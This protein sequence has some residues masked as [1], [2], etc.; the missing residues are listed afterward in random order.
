M[1]SICMDRSGDSEVCE[2]NQLSVY[3]DREQIAM[4]TL[5]ILLAKSKELSL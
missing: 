2:L 1:H 3:Y 5:I 4:D